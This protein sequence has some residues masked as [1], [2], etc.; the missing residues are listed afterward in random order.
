M[1]PENPNLEKIEVLKNS[2]LS[3]EKLKEFENFLKLY[4]NINRENKV[5]YREKEVDRDS[6][7]LLV[8]KSQFYLLSECL[9]LHFVMSPKRKFFYHIP[10]DIEIE[11]ETKQLQINFELNETGKNYQLLIFEKLGKDI[12]Y[13]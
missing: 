1:N 4:F 12:S 3:E 10:D 9:F 13:T 6:N 8:L 5:I 2:L 7:F 11:Q